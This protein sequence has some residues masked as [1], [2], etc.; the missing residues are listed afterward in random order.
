MTFPYSKRL[1]IP[2]STWPC[3]SIKSSYCLFFSASLTLKLITCF[4]LCAAILPKSI[5]GNSSKILSP[6]LS[7]LFLLISIAFSKSISVLG[8]CTSSDI[9]RTL[10]IFISP[11]SLSIFTAILLSLPNFVNAAF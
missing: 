1:I 2:L 5:W 6:I 11:F 10:L 4:A 9:S 7:S 8:S 3:F